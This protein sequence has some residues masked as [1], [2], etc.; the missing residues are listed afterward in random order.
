MSDQN[1]NHGEAEENPPTT[2]RTTYDV[3]HDAEKALRRFHENQ[4]HKNSSGVTHPPI[5]GDLT[6]KI[7]IRGADT[8]LLLPIEGDTAIGRRDPTTHDAPALDLSPYGAYQMGISRRHAILRVREKQLEVVDLGSRN[9]TFVNGKRLKPHQA[10]IIGNG[11]ELRL[12]K[13]V[14]ELHFQTR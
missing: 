13:I 12:G 5:E 14:M 2:G 3:T 10:V 4:P 9:G 7:I 8:P 1:P 6:L 11:A